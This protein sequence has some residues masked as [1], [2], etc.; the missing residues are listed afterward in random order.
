L[1]DIPF[2][3]WIQN[4]IVYFFIFRKKNLKG[5]RKIGNLIHEYYIYKGNQYR[6]TRKKIP[7]VFEINKIALFIIFIIG[8]SLISISMRYFYLKE[9]NIKL[10]EVLANLGTLLV[11]LSLTVF[12][13]IKGNEIKVEKIRK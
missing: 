10:F 12:L 6:L 13:F 4:K 11:T 3:I 5:R 1:S 9:E 7:K 2:K 8:A